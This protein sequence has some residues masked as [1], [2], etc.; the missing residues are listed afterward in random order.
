[1]ITHTQKIFIRDESIGSTIVACP[2]PHPIFTQ[3]SS[4]FLHPPHQMEHI[5]VEEICIGWGRWPSE[6]SSTSG[7]ADNFSSRTASVAR[8]GLRTMG[9]T[10]TLMLLRLC[11]LLSRRGGPS[12]RYRPS[13]PKVREGQKHCALAGNIASGAGGGTGGMS[14][15]ARRDRSKILG[16]FGTEGAA[17]QDTWLL[18]TCKE[19]TIRGGDKGCRV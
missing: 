10:E 13:V 5:L 2:Q 9:L 3:F 14:R 7:Q 11:E 4:E 17:L 12:K 6:G 15:E 16:C 19:G 1:M 18:R 8:R